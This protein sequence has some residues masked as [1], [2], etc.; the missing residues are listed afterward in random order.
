MKSTFSNWIAVSNG[1]ASLGLAL[2]L[3]YVVG[4]GL[5]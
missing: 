1:N 3:L 5:H 4:R 2:A